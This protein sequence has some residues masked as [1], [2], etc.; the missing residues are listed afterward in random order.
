MRLFGEF[1]RGT[2]V[3]KLDATSEV[4]LALRYMLTAFTCSAGVMTTL[5]I[6]NL[7]CDVS[8]TSWVIAGGLAPLIDLALPSVCCCGVPFLSQPGVCAEFGAGKVVPGRWATLIGA[9]GSE[10]SSAGSPETLAAVATGAPCPASAW[11]ALSSASRSFRAC[12]IC[13]MAACICRIWAF[14]CSS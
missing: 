7:S 12:C 1:G 3:P 2:P 8:T 9:A 4:M 5:P 14:C 10:S 6:W 13:C 11:T